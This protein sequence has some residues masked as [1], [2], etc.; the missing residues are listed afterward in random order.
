MKQPLMKKTKTLKRMN[1]KEWHNHIGQ[2]FTE[3]EYKGRILQNFDGW[4]TD[5]VEQWLKTKEI[6]LVQA[7]IK[8]A[9]NEFIKAEIVHC[10]QVLA[11]R[12]A[13]YVFLSKF[14]KD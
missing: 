6:E 5:K 3:S 14:K 8:G 2:F 13:K 9:D 12:S 7:V 1:G 11:A 4:D 10:K